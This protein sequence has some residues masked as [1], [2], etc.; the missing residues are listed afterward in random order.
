MSADQL[1][2]RLFH[3]RSHPDEL[4]EDWGFDGP[5]LGPLSGVHLT[6]GNGGVF[7]HDDER[8]MLPRVDDLIC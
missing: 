1:S 4:L 6:Y 2:V 3:G 5:C 8:V 7:G